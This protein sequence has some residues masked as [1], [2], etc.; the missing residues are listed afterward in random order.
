MR[1]K[2]NKNN[3]ELKKNEPVIKVTSSV[4]VAGKTFGMDELSKMVSNPYV[5]RESDGAWFHVDGDSVFNAL[6]ILK[7]EWVSVEESKMYFSKADAE[8]VGNCL[9]DD[10]DSTMLDSSLS[11]IEKIKM[12]EI[13]IP[14][15]PQNLDKILRPYQK[16]GVR[17]LAERCAHG[18][19]SILAD[20]MGLGK[21]LQMLTLIETFSLADSNFR[22]LV[23]CPASV[24]DAWVTQAHKFCPTLTCEAVRGDNATREAILRDSTS[25]LLVTH[26]GL[27]R[28]DIERLQEHNFSIVALDE[29]HTIKNSDSQIAK[30]VRTIRA[31][32]RIAMTGTPLENHINDLWSILDFINPMS[33]G[34][35][36]EFFRTAGSSIGQDKLRRLLSLIMLRRTKNLVATDLPSKTEET[37]MLDMP[38][39][40]NSY[41]Q[42]ELLKARMAD[43]GKPA[44]I[45][46]A[47]TRLRRLCCAPELIDDGLKSSLPSPKIDF[48]LERMKELTENGH[49]VLVFSQFTSLLD[50]IRER[51]DGAKIRNLTI[52]GETPVSKRG[53]VVRDFNGS[54]TPTVMLLSLKAAGT[55]LTLTKADYVFLFD[56]WWNPSAENQAI[57]RTHR[58]GQVN[59]VFA[60]RIILKN[61]IEEK[62]LD[63]VQKKRELFASVIDN[64]GERDAFNTDRA[65]L[66]IEELRQ[67]IA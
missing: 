49:S 1:K 18:L 8:L 53:E 16:I 10:M 17:F 32:V 30:S 55:G 31:N 42:D 45:L 66:S 20:D 54:A 59:P 37:I 26:Y 2:S 35:P 57:D 25:R 29:A 67:L 47:L 13:D 43:E 6:D 24:I 62:V 19:G 22:A 9:D 41:Y 65:R 58:I 51:L 52:T 21:T 34:T 64:N 23:I 39:D 7:K 15:I 40:M 46:A 11:V 60:Y 50:I 61:T 44:S 12:D 63:I 14:E 33:V 5:Q 3:A 38:E 27:V 48:L 4:T 56:P 36:R 28:T